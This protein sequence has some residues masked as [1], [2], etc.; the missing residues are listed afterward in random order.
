MEMHAGIDN[1]FEFLG[2]FEVCLVIERSQA[3]VHSV[4]GR[5]Q[6][7]IGPMIHSNLSRICRVWAH[8]S[9][10]PAPM[11]QAFAGAG[12]FLASLCIYAPLAQAQAIVATVNGTPITNVDVEQRIK[13]L[14]ILHENAGK[15]AALQSLID[16]NLKLDET[17]KYKIKAGDAEIGQQISRTAA[18]LKM[19]PQALLAAMRAAGLPDA[20]IKDHFASGFTFHVLMQAYHKGIEASETQI[21]A[22]LAKEGGKAAAGTDYTVHQIVF[23]IPLPLTMEKLNGRTHAAEQLRARFTDC[24]TGLP[25]ARG[26]DDVAVKEQVRRNAKQLSEPVRQMLDNT[27]I[28]HLTPPART[29]EGIEMLAVCGKTA[30]TDDTLARAAISERLLAAQLDAE[31]EKKL[32]EL[33]SQAVIEKR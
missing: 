13:L 1:L 17:S 33:R 19:E 10:L 5:E 23:T 25:L 29:S 18:K 6:L 14:H 7:E 20:H 2:P 32:L 12:L 28:G 16:D 27:A 22:E 8:F 24:T 11:V 21:R 4:T 9:R 31:G 3:R 15:D 30:S 26:M